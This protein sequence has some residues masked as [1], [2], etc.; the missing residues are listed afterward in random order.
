MSMGPSEIEKKFLLKAFI[1]AHIGR[2]E[3]MSNHHIC[4]SLVAPLSVC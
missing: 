1:F 2:E 3:Y 4:A